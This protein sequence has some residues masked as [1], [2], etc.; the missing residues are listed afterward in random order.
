MNRAP[1]NYLSHIT[2]YGQTQGLPLLIT[3]FFKQYSIRNR[4]CFIALFLAMTFLF[5]HPVLYFLSSDFYSLNEI[6]FTRYE[7][8]IL[9]YAPR[10]TLYA[11]PFCLR[12]SRLHN[13]RQLLFLRLY[14][15]RFQIVYS[16]HLL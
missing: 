6:R 4:D 10:S 3:I 1:T 5:L 2:H 13:Q 8:R 9:L 12:P 15:L 7:I 11:I 14:F 16:L